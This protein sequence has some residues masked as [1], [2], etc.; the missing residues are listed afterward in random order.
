MT[1]NLLSIAAITLL[2]AACGAKEPPSLMPSSTV[3]SAPKATGTASDIPVVNRGVAVAEQT[4]TLLER[5]ALQYT[6]LPRCGTGGPTI[7]SSRAVV[8]NIRKYA[9]QAHNALVAA[10][11]N[12]AMIEPAWTAINM[13]RSVIP[14]S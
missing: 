14:T 12:E 8:A 10:R 7:C 1:R 3:I 9:I 11:Q 4:L 5:A 6:S 2:L 13:L